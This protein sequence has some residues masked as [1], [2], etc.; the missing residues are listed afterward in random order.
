M[1]EAEGICVSALKFQHCE[2]AMC[3]MSS[4][5]CTGKLDKLIPGNVKANLFSVDSGY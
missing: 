5:H 1:P 3:C 4:K 2:D